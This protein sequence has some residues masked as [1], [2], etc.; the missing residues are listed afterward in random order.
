MTVA[1]GGT[2]T[3][4]V[5]ITYHG[6]DTRTAL[7]AAATVI[8]VDPASLTPPPPPPYPNA[9]Y[10]GEQYRRMSPVDFRTATSVNVADLGPPDIRHDL[11]QQCHSRQGPPIDYVLSDMRFLL[12]TVVCGQW[13]GNLKTTS[14]PE[15]PEQMSYDPQYLVAG[16][17]PECDAAVRS[18]IGSKKK[19]TGNRDYLHRR[20]D[21]DI[22]YIK[23]YT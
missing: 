10:H 23:F 20:F 1:H 9:P 18:Y 12:N 14:M 19:R 11:S 7:D 21:W 22:S 13:A 8:P 3:M 6:Y 4:T 16:T 5:P 15:D 17:T 2:Y